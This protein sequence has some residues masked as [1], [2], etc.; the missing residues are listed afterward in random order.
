M[1]FVDVQPLSLPDDRTKQPTDDQW[2][3]MNANSHDGPRA[4]RDSKCKLVSKMRSGQLPL[5]HSAV[6]KI[7]ADNIANRLCF[8]R[9]KEAKHWKPGQVEPA[10][11]NRTCRTE[12]GR[13]E[14][15]VSMQKRAVTALTTMF[16]V[17]RS[18]GLLM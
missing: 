14:D 1:P 9:R 16:E 11:C 18:F 7:R 2:L 15:R 13:I 4:R 12:V 5:C 17:K 8:K 10:A 6:E 3:V